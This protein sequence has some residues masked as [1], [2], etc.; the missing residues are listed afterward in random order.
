MMYL[1]V[2]CIFDW[3]VDNNESIFLMR[4]WEGVGFWEDG[5]DFIVKVIRVQM[6]DGQVYFL[7]IFG[8]TF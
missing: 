8:I 2:F 7:I 6:R 3:F 4:M 5:Q 1:W